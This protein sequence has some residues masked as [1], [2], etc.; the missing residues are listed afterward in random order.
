MAATTAHRS[1]GWRRRD[2]GPGSPVGA[3]PAAAGAGAG[4]ESPHAAAGTGKPLPPRRRY[5]GS[6]PAETSARTRA[7]PSR[8]RPCFTPAR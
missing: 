2:T 4:G 7:P 3:A 5:R 1:L 6:D 8:D